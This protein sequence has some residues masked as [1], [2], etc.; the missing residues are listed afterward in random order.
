MES[1]SRTALSQVREAVAG[2]RQADLD[3]E[4][5]NAHIACEARGIEFAVDR[6]A[7]DLPE[8][9]EPVLAMCLREAITNVVRHSNASH[10]RVSLAR[11]GNE[12]RL[13]VA[14]DGN[15]GAIREGA[16]LAGMRERLQQ[17]GGEM[18]IES[19][20]GVTLTVRVPADAGQGAA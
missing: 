3:G 5:A 12:I 16:G 19:G 20:R 2:F 1:V 10:C 9:Q 11:E 13:T 17:V 15:S 7:M 14:D 18:S 4:L 8:D 6:S